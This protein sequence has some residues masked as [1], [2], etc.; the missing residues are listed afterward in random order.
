MQSRSSYVEKASAFNNLNK[1]CPPGKV[2]IYRRQMRHEKGSNTSSEPQLQKFSQ[3]SQRYPNH[4]VS[5]RIFILKILY[6][7]NHIPFCY[8]TSE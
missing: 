7:I 2:P 5:L 1:G 8:V 4:H 3:Y 6:F